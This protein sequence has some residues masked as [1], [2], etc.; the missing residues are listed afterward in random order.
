MVWYNFLRSIVKKTDD[1]DYEGLGL[2]TTDY[3]QD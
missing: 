1:S 2:T 3:E